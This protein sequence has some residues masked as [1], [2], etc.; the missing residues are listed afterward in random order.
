MFNEPLLQQKAPTTVTL[1]Q[2]SIPCRSW[3]QCNLSNFAHLPMSVSSLEDGCFY[4]DFKDHLVS[5][6]SAH[7]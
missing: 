7:F 4:K 3:Q 1:T 6:D 2:G 5:V